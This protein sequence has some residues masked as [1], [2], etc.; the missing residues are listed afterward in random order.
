MKQTQLKVLL[1]E[2]FLK[3]APKQV[4]TPVE[5]TAEEKKQF[6]D[7]LSSLSTFGEDIYTKR[8]LKNAV[9]ALK[10]ISDMASN[11][12]EKTGN[13]DKEWF[14]SIT[15]GRNI[16]QLQENIKIFERTA[17]EVTELQ[18]RL[19]NSYEEIGQVLSKYFDVQ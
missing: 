13:D 5:Y 14:D 4:E 19:S 18:H 10:T 6:V 3:E 17:R 1:Q 15:V 2:K 9:T 7:A 12:L 8:D 16:K 11:M